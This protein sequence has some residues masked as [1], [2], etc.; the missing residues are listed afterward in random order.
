MLND[1][2]VLSDDEL[3][4]ARGPVESGAQ[5]VAQADAPPPAAGRKR[6]RLSLQ[7]VG[8]DPALVPAQVR[9]VVSRKCP[10]KVKSKKGLSPNCFSRFQGNEI[11]ASLVALRKS[12]LDMN[13]ED[14]DRKVSLRCY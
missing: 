14:S 6:K 5:V 3:E 13:K 4:V 7:L 11:V 10:C 12:L 8:K 2:A 9:Q 1:V